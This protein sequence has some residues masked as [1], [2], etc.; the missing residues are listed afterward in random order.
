M[1][2]SL[3]EILD[4]YDPSSP[5]EEAWTIPAP[6]YTDPR[7][8]ELEKRTV[9]GATWQLAARLDQLREP[10]R[11]VT[12]DIAGEPV[13]VTRGQDGQLR[14]FYN[15]CRHHAAVVMT[16]PEGQCSAMRCPYHG[17]TYGLDGKLKAAPDMGAVRC[18]DKARIG[19]M[20]LR[21]ETWENLVFV[22]Q[23]PEAPAL[24]EWL[25]P[26]LPAQAAGLGVGEF[27]FFER[28]VY[29]FQSNWK[30][31]VDNYLDGGYHIPIL[32]KS[33]DAVIDYK[34]YT[35]ENYGR[36]CLQKSP[37]R[38]SKSRP[39]SARLRTGGQAYYYW[40][41]PNFMLNWYQGVMD[42][43]LVLPL[44]PDRTMVVFDFYFTDVSPEA[45]GRNKASVDMG[46]GIQEEDQDISRSVQRGL[47]SRSY[48]A[49][50]LSAR[51]EAGEQLFHRLLAE[52]LRRAL[53]PAA[54]SRRD[55]EPVSY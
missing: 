21:V 48:R 10:G 9:F 29:E 40:L 52:D 37:L 51:R 47:G 6:W 17:W 27:H 33:L 18:F 3:E 43:N 41:Y 50:R 49:G 24:G 31:Y 36:V 20:P 12:A 38:D 44:G 28:R 7:V 19:L 25:G 39:E 34:N 16:Q 55:A 14:A 35:I 53:K 11:Y 8:Y 54:V 5:L 2:R 45:Y 13:V 26:E 4:L 32:H 30:V 1:D 22:N 42:T 15:V 23:D 46:E